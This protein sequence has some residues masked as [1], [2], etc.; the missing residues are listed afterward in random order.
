MKIVRS[1]SGWVWGLLVAA[2]ATAASSAQAQTTKMPSTLR[3]GSGY[4]DVPVASVLPHLAVTG[5]FSG[6]NVNTDRTVFVDNQGRIIG[7]GP[8]LSQ[9]YFDGS[10]ALGLFDRVEIGTTLQ[11]FNDSDSGGNMW[12]AFGRLALLRPETE[13]IGLAGGVRYVAAPSFDDDVNYQPPRLGFPDRD[14]TEEPFDINTELSFYGVASAM[15]R[16]LEANWLP[17]WDATVSIGYGTGMFQDG[18]DYEFYT[19]AD[20]KGWFVGGALHALLG[21]STLLNIMGEWNGFDVNLGLQ[22]DFS[23]IRVGGHVL[24][25]NYWTDVGIYRSPKYG[26]LA[27][28]CLDLA[29]P[30]FL[31]R[32]ALMERPVMVPDTVRLPAPPPD[33]VI[34]TREPELPTGTAATICLAT[35]QDVQVIVTAQNDTLVGPTRVSIRTLRPGV[36]FAGTYAEGRDW[37]VADQ[38]I[39]FEERQYLKSGGEVSLN[40]PDII[41]VGEFMG[42]PLFAMRTAER[43]FEMLY[44]PVRPG[45]WQAYQAGLPATRG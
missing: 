31:C 26:F 23:G 42:V 44:V 25:A 9:W 14:F 41:R 37:F 34:V 39:V 28:A 35:G 2:V 7:F 21:E 10:V 18:D 12:G 17:D 3:Y 40:C 6:F 32:P 38:P 20:S 45:V 15:L 33:T 36:V 43:P 13:G 19:Y 30:T 29:G 27:S 4:L 22:L 24:G 5:T 16:G 8:E 11:S 1:S